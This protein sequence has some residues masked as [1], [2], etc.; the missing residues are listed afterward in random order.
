MHAERQLQLYLKLTEYAIKT[1][2][3]LILIPFTPF[4][5][6]NNT[7]WRPKRTE[8]YEGKKSNEWRAGCVEGYEGKKLKEHVEKLEPRSEQFR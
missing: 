1:H 6:Q 3:A 7:E 5:S 4:M 8:G 2:Y